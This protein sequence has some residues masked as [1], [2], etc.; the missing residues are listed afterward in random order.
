MSKG[1]LGEI[2]VTPGLALDALI[3]AAATALL[4]SVY[5]AWRASRTVIADALRH[6][7]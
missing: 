3:L 6:G 7:R 1:F 5:P 2:L 4:A